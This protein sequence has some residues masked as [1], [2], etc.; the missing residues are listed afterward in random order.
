MSK[1]IW[2]S[3]NAPDEWAGTIN[4]TVKGH[5]FTVGLNKFIRQ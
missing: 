5:T 3:G 2:V 4:I 1:E